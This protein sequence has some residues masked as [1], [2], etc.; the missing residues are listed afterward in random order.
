MRNPISY[1]CVL[2]C[3]YERTTEKVKN[4]FKC[5]CAKSYAVYTYNVSLGVSVS[6]LGFVMNDISCKT[7]EREGHFR[8]FEIFGFLKVRRQ[9]LCFKKF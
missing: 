3:V 4:S 6:F 8:I 5:A 2:G 9:V 1:H 7:F